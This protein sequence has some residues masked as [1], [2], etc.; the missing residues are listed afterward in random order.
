MACCWPAE[1]TAFH[2]DTPERLGWLADHSWFLE[3]LV[4][5]CQF[6]TWETA[7]GC[8]ITHKRPRH[9]VLAGQSVTHTLSKKGSSVIPLHC[10][11]TS[12]WVAGLAVGRGVLQECDPA[13]LE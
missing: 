5:P 9:E 3:G 11:L 10:T 8:V 4:E 7:S 12:G 1:Y 2:S 13:A 6:A